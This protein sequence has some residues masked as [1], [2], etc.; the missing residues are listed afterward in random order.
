MLPKMTLT[1]SQKS[2]YAQDGFLI[3]ENLLSENEI[4]TFLSSQKEYSKDFDPGLRF[5]ATNPQWD[6]LARHPNTAGVA[7][8]LLEAKPRIVQSMYLPKFSGQ[9]KAENVGIALHQDTHY[10]PTEPN[11]LMACWIALTDTSGDNG[12]LCVVPDSH[13]HGL[14]DTDRTSSDEHDNWREEYRMRDRSGKEWIQEF[15][16]FEIKD[17]ES[18]DIQKLEVP[19]GA[20]VFFTGMTIHGSYANLS[21]SHDRL[22]FAIHY[23]ADGTWCTRMDVQE[24]IL[25][26]KYSY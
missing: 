20:A 26:Q 5:H 10:L 6:Y 24:T 17:L 7:A 25:V 3:L 16:S 2:S 14:Y 4:N 12:G 22:A 11:T 19:R 15:H 23:V 18:M 9:T 13:R 1:L 8:Q 21:P